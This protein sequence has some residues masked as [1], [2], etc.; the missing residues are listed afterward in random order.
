MKAAILMMTSRSMPVVMVEL[1]TGDTSHSRF[2]KR[3]SEACC[4]L[5]GD[6]L[7]LDSD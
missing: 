6:F 7:C 5:E 4:V 1:E 3:Y 2:L